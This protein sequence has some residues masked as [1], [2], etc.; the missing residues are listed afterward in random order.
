MDSRAD[1]LIR[2]SNYP[3]Y[4]ALLDQVARE[5]EVTNLRPTFTTNDKLTKAVVDVVSRSGLLWTR[6]KAAHARQLVLRDDLRAGEKD[7]RTLAKEMLAC[8]RD[9]NVH[10][11]KPMVLFCFSFGVPRSLANDL[12][13]M[14]VHVRGE[15]EEAEDDDEETEE[16]M[17]DGVLR[18]TMGSSDTPLLDEASTHARSTRINLDVTAAIV[19]VTDLSNSSPGRDARPYRLTSVLGYMQDEEAKLAAAAEVWTIVGERELIMCETALLRFRTI[20]DTLGGEEES[21]RAVEL[22]ARV[23]VVADA[24]SARVLS[25]TLGRRVRE[26]NRVVFGTG[27]T[28]QC[29]TL[30]ANKHFVSAAKHQGV[31]LSVEMH[32]A[33]ALS[34]RPRL[35]AQT[36]WT[37]CASEL[38]K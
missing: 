33:R 20:I 15:V 12:V 3:H 32:S 28:L 35:I 17:E 11:R 10:H 9:N 27:D 26:E 14:G 22:V 1:N 8:A 23:T 24:P 38:A 5:V 29:P 25:L 21:R 37:S 19:I 16:E 4:Q 7:V 36:E 2:C 6:V 34:E 31:D 13:R 18:G 30:T